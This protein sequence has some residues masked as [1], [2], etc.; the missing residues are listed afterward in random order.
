MRHVSEWY[1]CS[2]EGSCLRQRA[3]YYDE[4]NRLQQTA[5]D[6]NR[7][8]AHLCVKEP[9][10]PMRKSPTLPPTTKPLPCIRSLYLHIYLFMHLS[11]YVSLYLRAYVCID[12]FTRLCIYVC[13]Y[14]SEHLF[15]YTSVYTYKLSCRHTDWLPRS[16]C[17]DAVSWVHT[18][19]E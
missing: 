1:V 2:T 18:L 12:V 16:L 4:Y 14:A 17:H 7:K 11:I 9:C 5:I 13:I 8:K 3:L 6:C 19:A 15:T 10:I